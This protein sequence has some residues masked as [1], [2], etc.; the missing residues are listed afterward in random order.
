MSFSSATAIRASA[1]MEATA[2]PSAMETAA[3]TA[4]TA[5]SMLSVGWDWDESETNECCERYQGLAKS[6]RAHNLYLPD[7]LPYSGVQS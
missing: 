1:P 5:A 6:G 4:M 7:F 3:S 2:T